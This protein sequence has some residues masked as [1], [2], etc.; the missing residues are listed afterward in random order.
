[1]KSFIVIL[2]IVQVLVVACRSTDTYNTQNCNTVTGTCVQVQGENT[3]S[4]YC[5]DGMTY[6]A[7]FGECYNQ[8]V[9]FS[10]SHLYL[11]C[12]YAVLFLLALFAVWN[13]AL[14]L[15]RS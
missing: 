1:M 12:I 4:S 8:N 6:D 2:F 9:D 5:P 7:N 11:I 15:F 14:W 3:G 13:I 10:T